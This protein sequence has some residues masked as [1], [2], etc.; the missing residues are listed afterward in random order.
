MVSICK[1]T[2]SFFIL[3]YP[4]DSSESARCGCEVVYVLRALMYPKEHRLQ[5]IQQ[6]YNIAVSLDV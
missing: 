5:P 6:P 2:V 3:S 1:G 4:N